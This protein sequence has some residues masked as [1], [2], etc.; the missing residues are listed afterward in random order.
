VPHEPTAQTS[1]G[2]LPE[3]ENRRS[4]VTP[5]AEAT[6]G[7]GTTIQRRPSQ[8]SINVFVTADRTPPE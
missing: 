3:T 2:R 6:F 4:L 8:C 1:L 7:L 5:P